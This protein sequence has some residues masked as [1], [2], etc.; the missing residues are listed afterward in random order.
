MTSMIQSMD[1][2]SIDMFKSNCLHKTF[3]ELMYETGCFYKGH[4]QSLWTHL[5]T[6][7]QTLWRYGDSLF[8]WSTSLGKQCTSYNAPP[9]SREHA[10][11]HWSLQNFS[12]F[13][14]EN[15]Q[16][17]H[18]VRSGLYGRC[19]N[20]VLLIHFFQAEHKF[21]SDLAS[22]F[23]GFSNHEKGA[24]RQEISK[25]SMVVCSM[26]SRSGWNVVRSA[27]LAKGG[28]SKKRP[29]LHLH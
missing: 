23:L 26:F 10:A 14:V 13:M 9:T 21:N 4:F 1:Q 8:F 19:S 24:P 5:I 11:D 17:L 6:L 22:W 28:T 3:S 25:W 15:A 20:G 12:L 27:S 2:E 16:K 7:S 29:S 18:G